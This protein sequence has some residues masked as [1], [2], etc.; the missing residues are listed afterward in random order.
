LAIVAVCVPHGGFAASLI[1]LGATLA[2]PVPQ[3]TSDDVKRH[4]ANLL[5]LQDS[6]Q[7]P[8]PLTFLQDGRKIRGL[9]AGIVTQ[10]NTRF[11]KVCV[12]A[13]AAYKSGGLTHYVPEADAIQLQIDLERQPVL[14][15]N[16]TGTA[17]APH[18]DFVKHF[19]T[20]DDLHLIHLATQSRVMIIGR[21]N[22]IR[23]ETTQLRC[24][25]PGHNKKFDEGVLN[26]I[27]RVRK[28]VTDATKARVSIHPALRDTGPQPEDKA[29]TRLAI[30]DGADAYVKWGTSFT[31]CHLMVVLDR[32][33]AQFDEGLNQLNSRYL[34]RFAEYPLEL[35][36][37]IPAGID[38]TGFFERRR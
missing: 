30:F 38:A 3:P 29:V 19:Y 22:S 1:A 21:V 10:D 33:E 5:R 31:N 20:Q 4:F 28:F 15:R 24:A 17:L 35:E 6:F 7:T 27:L 36:T 13:K 12:Q 8:T 14:G 26:D 32:T 9:F 11:V 23:E 25:I 37:P 34:S 16:A 2:E 18:Y